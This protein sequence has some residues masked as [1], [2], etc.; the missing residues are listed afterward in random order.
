MAGNDSCR[1]DPIVLRILNKEVRE[2]GDDTL[3]LLALQTLVLKN[4]A[5]ANGRN[6]QHQ[7][8]CGNGIPI[9]P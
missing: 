3:V 7:Q 6:K 1:S 2:L 8:N 4:T 9:L 5:E